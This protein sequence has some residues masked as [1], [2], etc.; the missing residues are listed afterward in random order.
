MSSINIK[1][2]GLSHNILNYA[3]FSRTQPKF[4]IVEAREF[5]PHLFR[6]PSDFARACK[7]LVRH[8]FL[9]QV[10]D[11]WKITESGRLFLA[12]MASLQKMRAS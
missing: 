3:S 9:R 4:T 12:K 10:D 7:S 1:Y 5:W 8:G 2:G 6:K 11:G